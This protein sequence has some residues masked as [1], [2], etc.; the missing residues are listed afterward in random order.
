MMSLLAI[1]NMEAFTKTAQGRYI[2]DQIILIS[3][4]QKSIYYKL[5]QK[6][7]D[8]VKCLLEKFILISVISKLGYPSERI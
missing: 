6:L 4:L 2:T 8:P 3:H 1:K 7:P 5:F